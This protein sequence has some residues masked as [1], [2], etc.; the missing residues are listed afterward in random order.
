MTSNN[1]NSNGARLVWALVAGCILALP[2]GW[3][4]ATLAML[5]FFL[6][7]FFCMLFSLLVGAVVYRVGK[8]A[9]PQPR[10]RL[11][12]LGIAVGLAVFGVSLV[13]EYYNVRGYQ[14]IWYGDDG[15]EWQMVGGDAAKAIR[16]SFAY[17]SFTREQVDKLKTVSQRNFINQL[18]KDYPPGGFLGFI[19]LSL[20]DGKM[21][22]P[23]IFV[24]STTTLKLKQHG[25]V[26]VIR[27]AL[28]LILITAAVLTQVLGLGPQRPKPDESDE[29][30]EED[31][32][33]LAPHDPLE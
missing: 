2:I 33:K 6:G 17:K 27:L 30:M 1:A 24:D 12:L 20:G 26:W 18:A 28:S 8:P 31:K 32:A 29:G 11:W 25:K 4:L 21:E 14:V 16:R 15:F 10:P 22:C 7:L 9:A 23:R 3:L 13:C 19:K 5:P